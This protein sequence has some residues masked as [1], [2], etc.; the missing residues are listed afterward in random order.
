MSEDRLGTT[1]GYAEAFRWARVLILQSYR[2]IKTLRQKMAQSVDHESVI[3]HLAIEGRPSVRYSVMIALSC[4]IAILG[5]LLSSP[6]VIIGAML[7]S[8]LMSPIILFGFSLT[9]LDRDLVGRSLLALAAG[10]VLAV[11]QSALI[12]WLSPLQAITPEILARTRPN[13]FDLLVAFFS[14]IA[15]AYAVSQHKGETLVGVAIATALMPPLAVVGFG[16]ATLDWAVFRGAGGLFMTNMLVIGLTASMVAK[17]F[18]FA[19]R[20]AAPSTLWYSGSI[21]AVFAI[22]SIP[23]GLSLKQIAG[24]ALQTKVIRGTLQAYFTQ[25]SG[26]IYGVKFTFSEGAPIQVEAL[27]LVQK[28]RANAEAE[29]R[30]TLSQKLHQPVELSLS[31]IPIRANQS[32]SEQAINELNRRVTEVSDAQASRPILTISEIA[33][34]QFGI[35]LLDVSANESSRIVAIRAGV[36]TA[37]GLAALRKASTTFQKLHPGWTLQPRLESKGLPAVGFRAGQHDGRCAAGRAAG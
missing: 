28:A 2:T 32:V 29:L 31:Q 11:G 13:F 9:I 14:G 37:A 26:R 6:A 19:P 23:L 34:L 30:R 21:I 36:L 16:V 5:L 7:L 8:P 18:G 10:I 1:T 3:A 15:G 20:D 25:Y 22:L 4:A 27:V 12:V 24:E 33:A 35:P 17:L